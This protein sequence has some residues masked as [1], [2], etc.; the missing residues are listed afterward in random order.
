M[1]ASSDGNAG[2]CCCRLNEVLVGVCGGD[3]RPDG[4]DGP[5]MMTAEVFAA[6]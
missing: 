4:V 3:G 5:H 1:K 2:S 6:R